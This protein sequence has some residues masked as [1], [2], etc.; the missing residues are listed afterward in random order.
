MSASK[1]TSSPR[2]IRNTTLPGGDSAGIRKDMTQHSFTSVAGKVS[3]I[4][5]GP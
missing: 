5:V 4:S 1:S 2:R 3:T